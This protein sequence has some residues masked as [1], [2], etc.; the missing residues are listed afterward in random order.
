M[1]FDTTTQPTST[2]SPPTAALAVDAPSAFAAPV[3]SNGGAS[4]ANAAAP[5]Q[6]L[7][8]P[9]PSSRPAPLQIAL[10]EDS[11]DVNELDDLAHNG[12]D[13]AKPAVAMNAHTDLN[14]LDYLAGLSVQT[15][16]QVGEDIAINLLLNP[17]IEPMSVNAL[18]NHWSV[19]VLKELVGSFKADPHLIGQLTR[20]SDPSVAQAAAASPYVEEQ[21]LKDLSNDASTPL[22]MR[23]A[24]ARN[25]A[26][27]YKVALSLVQPSQPDE[28]RQT[29]ARNASCQESLLE[30]LADDP[31]VNVRLAVI[32]NSST[33]DD[34]LKKLQGDSDNTVVGAANAKI[35]WRQQVLGTQH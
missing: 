31:V 23:L 35:A 8:Q 12:A 17:R 11:T 10:A 5:F 34:L 29:L 6:Y 32:E 24:M 22:E 3:T 27:P 25:R 9:S 13:D 1:E 7:A 18:F 14:T 28:V 19:R 26:I 20:H 21:R 33:D 30:R 16:D 15:Q 4:P 2:S